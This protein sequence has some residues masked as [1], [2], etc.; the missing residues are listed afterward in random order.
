M[1]KCLE[2][3]QQLE[4]EQAGHYC[5]NNKQTLE[6]NRENS[7]RYIGITTNQFHKLNCSRVKDKNRQVAL[8]FKKKKKKRDVTPSAF[9]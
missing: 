2:R 4:L 8:D 9:P 1:I 7:D 3:I 5:D 6:A